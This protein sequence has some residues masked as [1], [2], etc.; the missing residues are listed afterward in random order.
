VRRVDRSRTMISTPLC[1]L[2]VAAFAVAGHLVGAPVEVAYDGVRQAFTVRDPDAGRVWT[3]L[4]GANLPDG[5]RVDWRVEGRELVV[6]LSA[7]PKTP[8]TALDFP[9]P[10]AAERGDRVLLT[11][12]N[13]LSFPVEETDLG[14]DRIDT[15]WYPGRDMEM[16]CFGHHSPAAGYLAIIETPEDSGTRYR[17]GPNGLRQPNV[18][19]R[20]EWG[21]FGYARRVRFVFGA[22]MTPMQMA[23]RY[24]EEMK[25]KGYYRTFPE[26]MRAR[27]RMAARYRAL[28]GAPVVWFWEVEGDKAGFARE[29]KT[30][31]FDTF[32]FCGATRRDLG[33]WITPEEVRAVAEVPGALPGVYDIYRD[34]MDPANLPLIDCVRPYWPTNVWENGDYVIGANGRP[35]RGWGVDRKGSKDPKDRI[36]CALLCE[37]RSWPYART[38]LADDLAKAPHAVRMFDVVGGGLGEC[39]NPRHPLTRRASR[40]VRNDFF[41]AAERAFGLLAG[42]EDGNECFVASCSYFEGT[43]SAPNHYRV[44]GGRYMWRIYDEVPDCIRRGTDPATRVP[45]FDMVFHGCVNLYWYWCDYNNKFPALW[46][47]RDLF[48]FVTGEPPMYLFTR[49]TFARQRDRLAASHRLATAT[50]KATFGV[51]MRDYRWLSTDRMVQEAEFENGVVATVNFGE[52][53]FTLSD[54][55]VLAP[56]GHRL[57]P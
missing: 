46:H 40:V 27:P 7:D 30:L 15:S 14:T 23:L 33:A 21:R 28:A 25:R 16:A 43:M 38:R 6:E 56:G 13:G 47:R 51:P 41:A 3:T 42:T 5:F 26:K 1:F 50:A 10:F 8:M 39:R 9:R 57:T 17:V 37:A 44:D 20:S 55:F 36:G 22:R 11:Q 31:G 19:W 48:D 52:R 53:P 54:G 49:E 18:V 2:A 32:L 24:R 29:L 45:F 4:P 12:G 34:F 35:A